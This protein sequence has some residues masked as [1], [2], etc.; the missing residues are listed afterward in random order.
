MRTAG[1][2][3]AASVERIVGR[4]VTFSIV[5]ACW[6]VERRSGTTMMLSTIVG[7]EMTSNPVSGPNRISDSPGNCE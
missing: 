7:D 1:P 5:S 3:G 4:Y 6:L 2:V